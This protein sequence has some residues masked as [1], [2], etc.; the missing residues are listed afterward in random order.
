MSPYSLDHISLRSY[1][2]FFDRSRVNPRRDRYA[3]CRP[4]IGIRRQLA[5]NNELRSELRSLESAHA[6]SAFREP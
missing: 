4:F 6:D 3:I 2:L 1:V 5:L